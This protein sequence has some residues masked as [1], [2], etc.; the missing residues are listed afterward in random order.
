MVECEI[1]PKSPAG[2]NHEHHRK[3]YGKASVLN[4]AIEQAH[5]NAAL[6][7]QAQRPGAR[8]AP[9]ATTTLPPGSLQPIWLG[10][11]V[12]MSLLYEK[13]AARASVKW[14]RERRL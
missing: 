1:H 9:I 10:R 13:S 5:C 7:T 2:R 11:C 8:D 3:E 6:T 12:L 14:P 4:G